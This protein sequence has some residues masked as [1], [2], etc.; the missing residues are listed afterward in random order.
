[1]ERV[2]MTSPDAFDFSE[3]QAFRA[4]ARTGSFRQAANATG[5]PQSSISQRIGRL[6]AKLR[7]TLIE[8]TTRSVVLTQ[9]GR[10]MVVYA[11]AMLGLADQVRCHFDQPPK[12]GI[13]KLGIVE[14]YL[15]GD[16]HRVL[17]LFRRQHP[18]FGFRLSTGL[19]T[20]FFASLEDGGLDIVLAKRRPGRSLGRFLFAQPLVWV[21]DPASF[22]GDNAVPLAVYPASSATRDTVLEALRQAGRAWTITMESAS[23]AGVTAAVTAG[24]AVSAFGVDFVPPA[25]QRIAGDAGLPDLGSL[26]YVI[27]QRPEPRDAAIDAFVAILAAAVTS[28]F[29]HARP[30]D[31]SGDGVNRVP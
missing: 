15:V 27:D 8:R 11:D 24:L 29:D 19:S 3:I 28:R 20:R 10:D 30:R 21:G 17:T 5:L 26:D 6:E 12:Q 13:L 9:A 14:D 2:P 22:Q 31:A 16:L 23:L 4:V 25:V 18:R 1:M 7:H